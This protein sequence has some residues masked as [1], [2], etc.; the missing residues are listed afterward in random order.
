M[1]GMPERR[2][3]WLLPPRLA[4]AYRVA[5]KRGFV[6]CEAEWLASLNNMGM[7]D[8]FDALR[9]EDGAPGVNGESAYRL[10]VRCG[11]AGTDVE[12]LAS[13]RGADGLRGV[14]GKDG[15]Q[16]PRGEPGADGWTAIFALVSDGERRVM[17]V[18]DWVGGSGAKPERNLYIGPD[19]YTSRID[20]ATDLRGERGQPGGAA[21]RAVSGGGLSTAQVLA[22][23]E[24]NTMEDFDPVYLDDQINSGGAPAV[25]T[26]TFTGLP[27]H[28]VWVK[29][30]AASA[31]DISEARVRTDGQDPD[32]DTGQPI[33]AGLPHPFTAVTNEVR[34]YTPA[35]KTVSVTGYRRRT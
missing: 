13:L 25:L 17:Q 7:V 15:A 21:L 11:F 12:W 34:V 16:G 23:I 35:G 8:F 24:A 2:R 33:A 28:R 4:R 10:A 31:A 32:A 27:V 1:I 20:E 22:L 18:I 3:G 19:G 26:F 14:A 29:L 9:G 6:G 30:L 5:Q